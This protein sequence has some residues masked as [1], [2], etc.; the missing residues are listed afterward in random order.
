[1]LHP[2]DNNLHSLVEDK[3][4]WKIVLTEESPTES[5]RYIQRQYWNRNENRCL[6]IETVVCTLHIAWTVYSLQ[7]FLYHIIS[8]TQWLDHLLLLITHCSCDRT[9]FATQQRNKVDIAICNIVTRR[10]NSTSESQRSKVLSNALFAS[11]LNYEG[12]LIGIVN[13]R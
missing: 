13:I 3:S 9:G 10:S 4:N 12:W 6:I 5:R 7:A 8:N 1:M 11:C 2:E